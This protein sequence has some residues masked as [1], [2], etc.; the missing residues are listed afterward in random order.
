MRLVPQRGIF[1]TP[2]WLAEISGAHR[3]T[4]ER[5][6]SS[7]QLPKAVSLLARIMLEGELALVHPDWAGFRLDRRDGALWTP[8]QWPARPGD[9][10]AIKYR[11]AQVRELERELELARAV[12]SI[13]SAA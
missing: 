7:Q 11:M 4:V 6:R 8:E 1:A 13:R 3:T 10:L 5:W 2:E 12:R 9:L